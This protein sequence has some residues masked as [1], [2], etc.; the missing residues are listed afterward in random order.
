MI[1]EYDGGIE[2]YI[3]DFVAVLG[4]EFTAVLQFIAGAPPL[5]VQRYAREFTA[6]I[7]AHN[8]D[9]ITAWSAYP[10]VTVIDILRGARSL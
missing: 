5:P 3:M 9:K 7:I 2:S 10:E 6:W 8:L 4:D 1:T